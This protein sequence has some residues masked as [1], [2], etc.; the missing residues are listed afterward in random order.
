MGKGSL[1]GELRCSKEVEESAEMNKVF[2]FE[3]NLCTP[4]IIKRLHT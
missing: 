1:I 3:D 2:M 4:L